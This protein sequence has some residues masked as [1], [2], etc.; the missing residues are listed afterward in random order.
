MERVYELPDGREVSIGDNPSMEQLTF[1]KQE[2]ERQ[3]AEIA[4]KE[5]A[6]VQAVPVG[7][8]PSTLD[9][10]GEVAMEGASIV[11]KAVRGGLFALPSL[12]LD[13]GQWLQEKLKDSEYVPD[14]LTTPIPGAGAGVDL[15]R[16]LMT[17]LE[18]KT[19]LGQTAANIGAS[20]IGAMAGPGSMATKMFVG[21]G[22]GIGAEGAAQI[23]DSPL[24]RILGGLAGGGLT[25]LTTIDPNNR[26]ALARFMMEG[27]DE[28]DVIKAGRT[29]RKAQKEGVPLNL[30]QAMDKPSNIDVGTKAVAQSPHGK[31]VVKQLR[32]QPAA[33][34]IAAE[35]QLMKLPGE[36]RP[37]RALANLTQ[38]AATKVMRDLDKQ[39]TQIWEETFNKALKPGMSN[40]VPVDLVVGQYK[41]IKGMRKHYSSQDSE[42]KLLT[43]LMTRLKPGK[44]FL[45][46]ATMINRTLRDLSG[47]LTHENLSKKGVTESAA[48][49]LKREIGEVHEELGD[50]LEPYRLANA[51][52]KEFT[53]TVRNPAMKDLTGRLAGRAGA[54]VDKEAPAAQLQAILKE[55][56]LPGVK[57]KASE[58][59]KLERMFAKA[60][61]SE[62]FQDIIKTHLSTKITD[63]FENANDRLPPDVAAKITGALGAPQTL[64]RA[65]KG[66]EEMLEGLGRSLKVE[67]PKAYAKGFK[68]FMKIVAKASRRPQELSATGAVKDIAD[69][70]IGKHASVIS[71]LMPLRQPLLAWGRALEKDAIS[72]MDKLL[73]SPDGAL[74]LVLLGK[75]PH[76]NK[77]AA[78]VI[79]TMLGTNASVSANFDK[80]M[81]DQQGVQ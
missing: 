32:Q 13:A 76:F 21:S 7:A 68:N 66:T 74:N 51:K 57:Q 20:A 80:A 47:S 59:Y 60:D 29:M 41:K 45:T 42:Y 78:N 19:Q 27:T 9:Q 54:A 43:K 62:T 36:Q 12:A 55:G 8:N 23:D 5:Q 3:Q 25:S 24:S 10:L 26:A 44:K 31:E 49:F 38:N 70:G 37:K 56:T 16:E 4:A 77:T 28:E 11:D 71:I 69:E 73:T 61:D 6:A 50:V 64:T 39:R 63:A 67:D 18:P 48:K 40:E 15:A 1:L 79:S 33:I 65:T 17:P 14:L 2:T 58:I 30:S 75:Q 81:P 72:T 22:A 46:K 53:D 34:S 52:Y 35:N